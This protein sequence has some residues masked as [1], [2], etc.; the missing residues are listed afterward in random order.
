M[1]DFKQE[2]INKQQSAQDLK[3]LGEKAG[4]L[5]QTAN[6]LSYF[7]Q[8]FIAAVH[9]HNDNELINILAHIS[10][11][12]KHQF[13]LLDDTDIQRIPFIEMMGAHA[14]AGVHIAEEK[15]ISG[16]P[17]S[18]VM[19]RVG[20][21]YFAKKDYTEAAQRYHLALEELK[22]YDRPDKNQIYAEYVGHYG[23]ALGMSGDIQGVVELNKALGITEALTEEQVRPFH[24]LILLTGLLLRLA[25]VHMHFN[26]I[27][28][29]KAVLVKAEPIAKD[30]D[31]THNMPDRL[32]QIQKF[33]TTHQ[34]L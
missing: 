30:L 22:E 18:A 7:E 15:G 8:A 24:K 11:I 20:D 17:K 1:T 10:I 12:Y 32:K 31:H 34:L 9:E 3:D 4:L 13:H 16:Q 5:G 19:L 2:D 27:E 29:A 25:E 23:Q 21:Y 26:N 6:A 33:K 28:E 14:Q